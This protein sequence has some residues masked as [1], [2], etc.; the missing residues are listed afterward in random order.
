MATGY[1]VIRTYT[2][3]MIG[4][5]VKFWVSGNPKRRSGRRERQ[6]L[7]KIESNDANAVKRSARLLNA[8]RDSFGV[9]MGFDYSDEGIARLIS[10]IKACG[11][12]WDG[13]DVDCK[14][15]SLIDAAERELNNLLARVNYELK[16]SGTAIKYYGVTSDMDGE[17]GEPVRVHHHLV[18]QAEHEQLFADKWQALGSV[19]WSPISEKQEDLLP[20]AV[21]L[22]RQVRHRDNRKMYIR[23]RNLNEPEVKD[24]VAYTGA[25]LR[26]PKRARIISRSEYKSPYH[27]Q[28]MRYVVPEDADTASRT[29]AHTCGRAR[30]TDED[31]PPGLANSGF[32]GRR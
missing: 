8:N 11:I 15:D 5:K 18:C 26:V 10:R 30:E 27:A 12:D 17:T 3:G 7:R 9:L 19:H 20:I 21:Y 24:R 6:S 25:E 13:L 28:Y 22:C 31:G 32:P 14:R 1:W 16:K 29:R 4:E 2:A 23:S